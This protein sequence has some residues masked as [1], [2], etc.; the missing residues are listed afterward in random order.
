[1]ENNYLPRI[2][3]VIDFIS[4]NLCDDLSLTTLAEIAHFSPFHFHRIFKETL[5]ETLNQFVNRLRIER[6]V[7]LLRTNHQLRILDVALVCGYE[8]AEGFSRA[9]KKRY[10]FSP[11]HWQRDELL[12]ERKIGQVDR[13][14][15]IYTVEEL[16][17]AS[18]KF[19]VKVFSLS[20]QR[21]A[22]I[23]VTD[24]YASWEEVVKQHDVLMAWYQAQGGNLAEMKLYGMS[25]DDPEVT[26]RELCRFDWCVAIPDDWHIPEHISERQFPACTVVAIHICGELEV[27]DHAL[28]YLW[29]YWLPHSHYQPDNL[30]AMEIYRQLPIRLGWNTYD[31]W[32]A[33]PVVRFN[34]FT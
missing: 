2:N 15:P 21:L 26:P 22:Y 12:K 3:R 31:M 24:S 29:R 30:P 10:G 6:A 14:F 17:Q 9:F 8:S 7:D 23:R 1:M 20:E 4:E 27:I 34:T 19:T 18:T 28:Q 13:E 32:C 16:C 5:G 33:V 11:N 25:Q